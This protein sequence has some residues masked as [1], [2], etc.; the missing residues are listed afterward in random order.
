MKS[1]NINELTKKVIYV[2]NKILENEGF[3]L[4]VQQNGI[5]GTQYKFKQI[6]L[7]IG[8]TEIYITPISDIT[9][10][11][12]KVNGFKID[13]IETSTPRV[14]IGAK[15]IAV[16]SSI[17]NIF[18]LDL[19]LWSKDNRRLKRWYRKLGFIENHTNSMGETLFILKRYNFKNVAE[20]LGKDKV[21]GCEKISTTMSITEAYLKEIF[22]EF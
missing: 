22:E 9:P 10:N 7:L 17:C 4:D 3:V 2:F 19:C 1:E 16:L 5:M 14:G 15:L 8:I 21:L 20:M 12:T 13:H 11:G 18:D 6:N